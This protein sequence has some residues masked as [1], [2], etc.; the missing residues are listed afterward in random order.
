MDD[1]VVIDI[2]HLHAIFIDG[3]MRHLILCGVNSDIQV[4]TLAVIENN[5]IP[6][7]YFSNRQNLR[8]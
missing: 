5:R 1:V 2:L 7:Q 6:L 8:L 4:V 3:L